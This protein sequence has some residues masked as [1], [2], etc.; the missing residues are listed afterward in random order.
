MKRKKLK[1]FLIAFLFFITLSINYAYLSTSLKIK[2]NV[3]GNYRD[4]YVIDSNS[5]PYLEV[6]DL[7]IN[8]WQESNFYKYQYKFN[9]KNTGT[10]T[11]DNFKV[12][13]NHNSNIENINIWNYEYLLNKKELTIIKENCN[14]KP[15]DKIEVNYIV[16]SYNNKFKISKIKL[17]VNTNTEEV[18]YDKVL[19]K[20]QPTNSWGNYT[21]QYNVTITNNSPNKINSWNIELP[22][23][24]ISYVNGW[25]A[26]FETINNTLIIKNESYNQIIQRNSSVTFGLQLN[27]TSPTYIPN[28]YRLSVR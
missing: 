9:V 12:T 4:Q 11:Y 25:N 28:S 24:N 16:S 22:L 1:Y 14:L 7:N 10:T 17:E 6:T 3:K 18:D 8:N 19:V 27:T 23:N 26:K 21:V 15:N 5:N 13:L 20:F 2:G